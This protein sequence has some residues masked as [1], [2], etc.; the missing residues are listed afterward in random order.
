VPELVSGASVGEGEQ[1][2]WALAYHQFKKKQDA[3]CSSHNLKTSRGYLTD[4]T[5]AAT[6]TP[7]ALEVA[8]DHWGL[9]RLCVGQTQSYLSLKKKTRKNSTQ[10]SLRDG[11]WEVRWCNPKLSTLEGTDTAVEGLE[12]DALAFVALGR[13]R[14]SGQA[15]T[16]AAARWGRSAG[17]AKTSEGGRWEEEINNHEVNVGVSRRLQEVPWFGN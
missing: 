7:L 13:G 17:T 12:S 15:G 6:T 9:S 10:R 4:D 1:R 5:D 2:L 11:T 3:R 16:F 14:L 8:T